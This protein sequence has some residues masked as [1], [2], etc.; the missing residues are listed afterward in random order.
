MHTNTALLM[1]TLKLDAQDRGIRYQ[2]EGHTLRAWFHQLR[3]AA[4]CTHPGNLLIQGKAESISKSTA[5]A[6]TPSRRG[7]TVGLPTSSSIQGVHGAIALVGHLVLV[8]HSA[9]A[10][11]LRWSERWRLREACA[12]SPTERRAPET[13]LPA[14]PGSLSQ[15]RNPLI[16]V[17]VFPWKGM[18]RCL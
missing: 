8:G 9:A 13:F 16:H 2:G 17:T 3:R 5:S 6:S 1:R 10:A 18:L 7:V 11:A 15:G 4:G 14:L 12:G